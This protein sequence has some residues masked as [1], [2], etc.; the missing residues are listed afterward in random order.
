[1]V[2]CVILPS[3]L[4]ALFTQGFGQ[5]SYSRGWPLEAGKEFEVRDL[6]ETGTFI[7]LAEHPGVLACWHLFALEEEDAQSRE[8]SV[9]RKRDSIIEAIESC[10]NIRGFRS[11]NPSLLFE[12]RQPICASVLR[13]ALVRSGVEFL[14]YRQQGQRAAL[15][16]MELLNKCAQEGLTEVTN[17]I[18]LSNEGAGRAWF[19][20]FN[21]WEIGYTFS[22]DKVCVVGICDKV[23]PG[24]RVAGDA[25]INLTLYPT[26]PGLLRKKYG[27]VV[28]EAIDGVRGIGRHRSIVGGT[29][30]SL[31]Q[32]ELRALRTNACIQASS[33]GELKDDLVFC[34]DFLE[35]LGADLGRAKSRIG[36][37]RVTL[38]ARAS[39]AALAV[40]QCRSER[41]HEPHILLDAMGQAT[42]V[43]NPEGSGTEVIFPLQ[44]LRVELVI[45]HGM[46]L[47]QAGL[48]TV[49]DLPLESQCSEFQTR[50]VQEDTRSVIGWGTKALEPSSPGGQR[51]EYW[52]HAEERKRLDKGEA[53]RERGPV[54]QKLSGACASQSDNKGTNLSGV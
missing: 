50:T 43:T 16:S 53:G 36:G 14:F 5:A 26:H 33:V 54:S 37:L 8:A 46:R 24:D 11:A 49:L 48:G 42:H 3:H 52:V 10:S 20:R 15:S 2:Q 18:L 40:E 47:V 6:P 30:S 25:R 19:A 31:C 13:D 51:G 23:E 39:S 22:S 27:N 45:S 21:L 7:Y 29:L 38:K 4:P 32:D 44:Q 9:R 17:N 35:Y 1:M 34:R 28:F 12:T 41:L